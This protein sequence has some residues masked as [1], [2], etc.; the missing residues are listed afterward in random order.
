MPNQTETVHVILVVNKAIG[1]HFKTD[2]IF[3]DGIIL[4]DGTIKI[5]DR[6]VRAVT[7]LTKVMLQHL[8]STWSA[9]LDPKSWKNLKKSKI[10]PY[11]LTASFTKVKLK[12]SNKN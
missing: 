7:S 5:A 9:N 3:P 6:N 12:K 4:H 11:I 1:K 8:H 2:I 10:K